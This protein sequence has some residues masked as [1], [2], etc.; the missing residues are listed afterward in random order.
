[1]NCESGGLPTRIGGVALH[2]HIVYSG[3]DVVWIG[4]GIVVTFMAREALGRYIGGIAGIMTQVTI[5]DRM[6]LGK[7][8]ACMFKNGRCPSG[9]G[10]MALHTNVVYSGNYMVW[11]GGSIVIG[12]MAGEA[13]G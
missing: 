8:K 3:G 2:A 6:A 7:R 4:G 10:G 11:I 13:I 9:H 1:M 5:I 12:L